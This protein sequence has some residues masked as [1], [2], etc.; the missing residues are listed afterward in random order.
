LTGANVE[1]ADLGAVG[2]GRERVRYVD[3][4][5]EV[6]NLGPSRALNALP[7]HQRARDGGDHARRRL[8]RPIGE[9]DP[10]PGMTQAG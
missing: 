6:S 5:Q 4:V 2:E 9:E 3:D 10:A 7:G 1:D 8:T